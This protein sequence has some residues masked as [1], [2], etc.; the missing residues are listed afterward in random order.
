LVVATSTG[1]LFLARHRA[2]TALAKYEQHLLAKGEKLTYHEL[3]PALPGGQNKGL[4][5][6]GLCTGLRTGAVLT[7]NMPPAARDI[8]PGKAL[9]I[10]EQPEWISSPRNHRFRWEQLADDLKLNASTLEQIRAMVR[11]PVLRYPISY[12]GFNTL[13]PHLAKV[14]S[15]AQHLSASALYNIRAGRIDAA[16]DDIEAIVLLAEVLADEPI[17]ISQLVRV[18]AATIGLQV[19]W[20]LL[21]SKNVSDEQLARLQKILGDIDLTPGIPHALRGERVMAR[22]MIRMLRSSETSFD[23]LID[24][25]ASTSGGDGESTLDLPYN[26]EVRGAIRALIIVPL[27]RSVWS[28]DDE[29]H[30]LEELQA[31]LVAAEQSSAQRST[32]PL[33]ATRQTLEAKRKETAQS[34][35]YYV[36]RMFVTTEGRAPLRAF[37]FQAH[38]EL[39][40]AAIAL[41]R[42]HL[43]HA[44]YPKTLDELVPD[45]L[46]RH[47]IDW[48]DGQKL[49][50]RLDGDTFALWSVGDNARDDGG[51]PN[52]VGN[53]FLNGP[54][55][56][57][58]HPASAAEVEE[59]KQRLKA[60]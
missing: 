44:K 5:L 43:R 27:W 49:R 29:R 10:T 34:W 30:T 2:K 8:A 46:A 28:Y 56:V 41:K 37:R 48:M 50:Y 31:V 58:P 38:R 13:L 26:E 52:Q 23:D 1:W 12:R 6:I 53:S 25:F 32:M 3:W 57:W 20:P 39:T 36:T 33:H 59:Y 51:A 7:L 18:S 9:L 19:C 16:V 17:L 24:S 55:I 42:Y 40:L 11:N 14:K 15:G 54:D 45:F 21:H 35:S 60:K 22:D 4:E 47:P